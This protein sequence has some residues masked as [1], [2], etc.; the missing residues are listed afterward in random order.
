MNINEFLMSINPEDS[1]RYTSEK[2]ELSN[3][4]LALE[5]E[6][7]IS[8]EDAAFFLGFDRLEDFMLYEF[9]A[10]N[11]SIEKYHMIIKELANYPVNE[12]L[13]ATTLEDFEILDSDYSIDD[14]IIDEDIQL[15]QVFS[16]NIID[17]ASKLISIVSVQKK[18]KHVLSNIHF[19]SKTKSVK[20][21]SII[22]NSIPSFTKQSHEFKSLQVVE[23]DITIKDNDY[24]FVKDNES[25]VLESNQKLTLE[26]EILI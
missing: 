7:G 6:K 10:D 9:G 4:I 25:G 3:K 16:H 5:V 12:E 20:E 23:N 19:N 14:L 1:E 18:G 8:S 11:T 26:Q 24:F 15:A 21:S 22:L 17:F 2:F 13:L